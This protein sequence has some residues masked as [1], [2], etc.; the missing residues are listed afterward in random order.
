MARK[1]VAPAQA[2]AQ[3]GVRVTWAMRCKL[4]P[5]LRRGDDTSARASFP[6]RGASRQ[7]MPLYRTLPEG[8]GGLKP[9]SLRER[10]GGRGRG[11]EPHAARLSS[12]LGLQAQTRPAREGKTVSQVRESST[13]RSKPKSPQL[14]DQRQWQRPCLLLSFPPLANPNPQRGNKNHLGRSISHGT[15]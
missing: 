2:G 14:S 7:C 15:T 13:R 3:L 4:G 11:F 1:L 10:G 6:F 9:L 12:G 8:E 5:G